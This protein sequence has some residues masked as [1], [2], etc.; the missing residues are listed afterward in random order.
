[1]LTS[2]VHDISQNDE[3]KLAAKN[4]NRKTENISFLFFSLEDIQ[5]I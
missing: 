2:Q 3:R 5:G 1:M 4:G